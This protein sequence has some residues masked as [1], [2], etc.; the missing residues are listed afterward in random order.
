MRFLLIFGLVSLPFMAFSQATNLSEN[1]STCFSSFPA[2]WQQY[3]VSGSD[4]WT[5][6]SSGFTNRAAYMNGYSSGGNN[7]NEDWLISPLLNFASYSS[8]M[9]SFWS[10]T[11]YAGPFVQVW[12]SNNYSGS[13]NPNTANWTQLAVTLPTSNSDVWFFTDQVSLTAFKSTPLHIAFKYLSTTSAAATWRIDDIQVTEGALTIPKKFVN[14]GQCAA[15]ATSSGS[16][17]QFTMN[18]LNGTLLL[19]APQPFELSKDNMNWSTQ[20]SYSNSVSGLA[21]TVFVRI[22]PVQADKI[23]RNKIT[24]TYNAQL[25]NQ[26]VDVLGTSLPDGQT[27]RVA[28]W[29]MR[30]FGDPGNCSC[31]TALARTRATMVLKDLNADVYCLQEVVS[32]SSLDAIR[33]SLGNQY[34]MIVSPYGSGALNTQSGNYAGAQKL[35]F[36]I[37]TDK[38]KNAGTFGLCA[39]MYPADTAAY[40]C[41]SSGRYPFILKASIRTGVSIY[42]TLILANIHAKASAT[43]TDYNRRLCGAQWMTDSLNALFPNRKRLI[44]GDYNDYLEGSSVSGQTTSPYQYLLNNGF[45]GVTLPSVYP[46]QTTF[47]GST[48]HLIDNVCYSQNLDPQFPDSACFIFSEVLDYIPSY[49]ATTSDHLPVMSYFKFS[50]PVEV[51]SEPMAPASFV[52]VS[53]SNELHVLFPGQHREGTLEVFDLQGRQML[54]AYIPEQTQQARFTLECEAGGI[55]ILRFQTKEGIYTTKWLQTL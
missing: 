53:P 45:I 39:S 40:Y 42:D 23:Y 55:R 41:F 27:I 52:V 19:S 7:T 1:F 33:N 29:N 30:W 37:N 47:V 15:T 12:V 35:A 36:L 8:P 13:G 54:K 46:N 48:D 17:F 21:Q 9:L 14:A 24:F 43:I 44:V 50:N 34:Q 10:R 28:N 11:K 51:E 5:C 38:L 20:L 26:Q 25:L 6:T 22:A 31:D 2:G 18:G 32:I 3:S 16:D 4:V 49:A